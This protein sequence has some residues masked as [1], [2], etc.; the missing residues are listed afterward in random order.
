MKLLNTKVRTKIQRKFIAISYKF[1]HRIT[2]FLKK[3]ILWIENILY[4]FKQCFYNELVI[5]LPNQKQKKDLC[6]DFNETHAGDNLNLSG[7]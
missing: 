1:D 4:D 5:L 7:M 3:I 2:I 6:R